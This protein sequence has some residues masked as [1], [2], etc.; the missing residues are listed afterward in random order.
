MSPY[1]GQ[2]VSAL[3]EDGGQGCPTNTCASQVQSLEDISPL[4][5]IPKHPLP[6]AP[7]LERCH[8]T[9]GLLAAGPQVYRDCC[10]RVLPSRAAR[11]TA[12]VGSSEPSPCPSCREPQAPHSPAEAAPFDSAGAAHQSP[13]RRAST[14]RPASKE[15]SGGKAAA[16]WGAGA[17]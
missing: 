9:K 8:R 11:V 14:Q 4:R 12:E 7:S 5:P 1:T 6:S 3:P 10:C 17:G 2:Q 16:G 15:V 13:P